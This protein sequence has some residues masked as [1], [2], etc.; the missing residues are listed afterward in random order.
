MGLPGPPPSRRVVLADDHVIF[1]HG[2]RTLLLTMY[3][4]EPYVLASLRAGVTGYVLKSSALHE[5]VHAVDAVSRGE[6]YLS[7]GV[8]R[9]VVQAFL[10][11]SPLPADPLSTRERE[12]LQLI[13]EGQNMKEIGDRLGISAR[14]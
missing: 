11:G 2:L 6:I 5:L 10:A 4:E 3:A 12:V 14:T 1:R 13:A 9:T 7:P 8:S